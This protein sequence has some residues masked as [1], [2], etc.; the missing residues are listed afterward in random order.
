[1]TETKAREHSRTRLSRTFRHSPEVSKRLSP[2]RNDNNVHDKMF[3]DGSF[4]KI[5][6]PSITVFSSSDYRRVALTDY[7]RFPENVD[8][9]GMPSRCLKAYHHLYVL[10]MTLVESSPGGISPI[11]NG[12]VVAHMRHRQQRGSC[13][14]ITGRP[15][16]W[17]WPC[18]HCGEYFQPVMDNMTGYRNNPDFVAAGQAARLMCPHCRG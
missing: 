17:Y 5:G 4:L 3:L 15:P 18:P 6:W 8:G 11:P 16:P 14:C 2:S 10:G 12:V 9:E 7:D 1:M 13:H